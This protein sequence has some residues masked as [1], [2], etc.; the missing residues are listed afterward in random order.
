[1]K[2]LIVTVI[3]SRLEYKIEYKE[4][5]G[6]SKNSRR[7]SFRTKKF[8]IQ[9]EIE[10]VELTNIGIKE[11]GRESDCWVL[12]GMGKMVME[13]LIARHTRESRGHERKLKKGN[14]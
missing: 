11:G 13:Y 8:N 7:V 12:N 9:R 2:E 14:P 4:N 3:H 6:D 10:V 1:M 5:R